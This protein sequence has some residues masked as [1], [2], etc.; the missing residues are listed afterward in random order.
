MPTAEHLI[1]DVS[2]LDFGNE[3]RKLHDPDFRLITGFIYLPRMPR[4]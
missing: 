3:Q 1:S 2:K 4:Q